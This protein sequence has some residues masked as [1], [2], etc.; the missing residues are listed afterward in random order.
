MA[1]NTFTIC[2]TITAIFKLLKSPQINSVTVKQLTP[3]S[4]SPQ[5]LVT[6]IL[7]C[8]SATLPILGTSYLWDYAFLSDL[9]H[10]IKYLS[11]WP[12]ACMQCHSFY[13]RII[14]ILGIYYILSIHWS[15]LPLLRGV[16]YV[17][18]TL[19]YIFGNPSIS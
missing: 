19:Y 13:G 8:V 14:L 11:Y 3:I 17:L 10:S 1:L 12:A 2:A 15:V 5:F 9:F 4:L 7:F 16:Q 18:L 6:S